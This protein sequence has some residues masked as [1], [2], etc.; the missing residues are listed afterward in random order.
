M[1]SFSALLTTTLVMLACLLLLASCTDNNFEQ[2]A[3]TAPTEFSSA[4]DHL[5]AASPIEFAIPANRSDNSFAPAKSSSARRASATTLVTAPMY[6]V[7]DL[8]TFGGTFSAALHINASSQIVGA[9]TL[10]NGVLHPFIYD[11]GQLFDIGTLGGN[12]GLASSI[13]DAGEI[14]GQA[15]NAQGLRRG[16]LYRNAMMTE[17]PTLGGHE[18]RAGGINALGQIVG[19]ARIPNG[20]EHAY[21]YENGQMFDL[22]TLGGSTSW[23]NQI[24]AAG[25]IAGGS[26]SLP[27]ENWHAFIRDNG[28]M[29]DLGTLGGDWAVAFDLNDVGQAVGWS[30]IVSTGPYRATLW[31]NNAITDLGTLGG[32]S[33][34][35][36]ISNTGKIVGHAF[37]ADNQQHAFLI[38]GG[39]IQDLNDLIPADSGW[40][41]SIATDISEDGRKIVGRGIINGE[42]HAF[43]LTLSTSQMIGNLI[44]LVRSFDL[45]N[46]G[47]ENSLIVKLEHAEDFVNAG[48]ISGACDELTAF[49]SEVNAQAGK[50]LTLDQANQLIAGAN[51]IKA[52]LGC[53]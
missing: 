8:G 48:D 51:Q 41:L 49:M 53:Q 2:V 13:N 30:Y 39:P 5:A 40:E 7:T 50:K 28:V 9:A 26:H 12:D 20:R 3:P 27:S 19:R 6:A 24:N 14:I 36:A 4:Q 25:Q 45:A 37:T 18:S 32:E 22:G 10:P 29:T 31:S 1:K 35:Y 33:I 46:E 43:L 11:N 42:N 52:A 34:A 44:D 16:F 38:N 21:L 15:D 23:A 47:I 17:I